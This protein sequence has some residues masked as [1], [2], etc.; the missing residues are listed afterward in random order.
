MDVERKRKIVMIGALGIILL[1]I[2]LIIIQVVGRNKK[3]EIPKGET[4]IQDEKY[5]E[6][7][8]DGTRKNTSSKLK[9]NKEFNGLII[10]NI[11]ITEKGNETEVVAD[12]ENTK[13][14]PEGDYG[15][16]LKIKND[17]GEEIKQIAGYIS[18]IEGKGTSKLRIKTS[19][20]FANAY[21]FEIVKQ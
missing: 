18:Y 6:K 3:E 16:Y 15:I 4:G 14:V 1:L 5:V 12:I 10:K 2:I 7:L 21:D 8:E 17:K 19:Y 11:E 9:E 13:N 20:D